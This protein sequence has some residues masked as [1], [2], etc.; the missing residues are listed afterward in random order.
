MYMEDPTKNIKCPNCG[1][2]GSKII[3]DWTFLEE[4]ETA[5]DCQLCLGTGEISESDWGYN[6]QDKKESFNE[7]L[8]SDEL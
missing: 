7:D 8:N 4:Y 3:F 5:E 1:G 2:V 6:Q